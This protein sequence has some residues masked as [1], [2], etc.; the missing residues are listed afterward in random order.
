MLKK[1]R[2]IGRL[3]LFKTHRDQ[4]DD[5]I[6]LDYVMDR[7]VI[8]GEPSSVVEQILALREEVGDFGE[9][10]YAGLDWADPNLARRSTELM[11]QEVMPRVNALIGEPVPVG[12]TN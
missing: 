11:A 10:V 7:L 12:S 9:I 5:E 6:T 8:A 1:M 3:E 2:K 4:P